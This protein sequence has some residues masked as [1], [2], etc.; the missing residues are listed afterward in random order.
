MPDQIIEFRNDS[1]DVLDESATASETLTEAFDQQNL[2]R[3]RGELCPKVG[4][5]V[6]RRRFEVA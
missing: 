1:L 5:G 3:V 4:D 6:I 2:E